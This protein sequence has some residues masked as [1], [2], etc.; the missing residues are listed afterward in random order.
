MMNQDQ[1]HASMQNKDLPK[2][3]WGGITKST[4]YKPLPFEP[5]NTTD[6]EETIQK[7]ISDDVQLIDVCWNNIR[8]SRTFSTWITL[9]QRWLLTI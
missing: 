2:L 1:Y 6:P 7:A 5:D 3:G 4:K 9:I 8:V